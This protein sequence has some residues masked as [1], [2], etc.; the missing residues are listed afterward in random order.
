MLLS[1]A[2]RLNESLLDVGIRA[3][4]SSAALAGNDFRVL[5][6]IEVVDQDGVATLNTL[7]FYQSS[8][9]SL[10]SRPA[11]GSRLVIKNAATSCISSAGALRKVNFSNALRTAAHVACSPEHHHA[12]GLD[13]ILEVIRPFL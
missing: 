8:R 12:L 9:P 2:V 10:G 7:E 1:L 5:R 13:Q 3:E 6:R 4:L 11:T